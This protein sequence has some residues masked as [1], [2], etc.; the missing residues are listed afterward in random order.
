MPLL[1]LAFVLGIG[2][3]QQLSCLPEL[4]TV[5]SFS[6]FT[7]WLGYRREWLLGAFFAGWLWTCLFAFWHLAHAQLPTAFEGQDL[8]IQG[9]ISSLPQHDERKTRFDFTVTQASSG[10][11]AILKLSW[12]YPKQ[13]LSA[14]QRWSFKVKLKKPHGLLNPGGFDYERWLFTQGVGATGYIRHPEAAQLLSQAAAWQNI[15]VLRQS[16]AERV[17]SISE[18]RYPAF[19]TALTIGSTDAISTEQWQ[20]LRNT[21]TLHLIAISGSHISLVAGLVYWLTRR[22]WARVGTLRY[23]PQ[24]VAAVAAI[25]VAIFYALLAGFSV[26]TQ[27]ALIMLSVAMIGIIW[28][29]H[30]RPIQTLA[31]AML[32]IVLCDPLAVLSAGFWLS[33]FAVALIFFMLS[34]RL[35]QPGYWISIFKVHGIMALGLMPILLCFFQQIALISPLANLIAVPVIGMLIVPIALVAVLLLGIVPSLAKVLLIAVDFCLAQ[36]W[37]FLDAL[38]EWPFSAVTGISTSVPAMWLASIGVLVLCM[39]SGLPG[40]WLGG[41]LCLPLFFNAPTP[42]PQGSVRMT[43]LDV[44]QGLATVIQTTEHVLIFDTG[45]KF[46]ADA[47][48]GQSVL[49]PFLAQ[50]GIR[51]IDGVIISH[52]DNDHIGGVDSLLADYTPTWLYTS[53]PAQLVD[54]NGQACEQ[55]QRWTWDAVEFI[56]LSPSH[57]GLMAENDNSCVLQIKTPTDSILLTGDI[58]KSAEAWLVDTYA[59]QLKSDILVAPHHGSNTSSTEPFLQYVDPSVVLIPSGYLN[60]FHFPHP[61]VLERY[62]AQQATWLNTAEQGALQVDI[63]ATETKITPF[64]AKAGKYWHTPRL[65]PYPFLKVIA[66]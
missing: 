10:V 23:S 25:L 57:E 15:T 4:I 1:V 22:L 11:P 44:G 66:G 50:Q 58:E 52:G 39:P 48:S 38:A 32:L 20:V 60:P 16:I 35:S 36:L 51:H 2:L 45:I 42:L 62:Q 33:F 59:E 64:R 65:Y 41:F 31:L 26:P 14:G 30:V 49:L 55:G 34:G 53:V 21:G 29:R 6:L 17:A 63:N 12:Y 46:S 54:Y 19:I 13:T 24:G 56:I 18:L 37:G 8:P 28:Q 7:V 27:R 47:D 9:I 3:F 61:A 43:L 5:S 40:R